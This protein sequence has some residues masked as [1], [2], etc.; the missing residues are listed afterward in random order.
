MNVV[1]FTDT[2]PP[3]INGVS[4]SCYNLTCALKEHGHKVLVITPRNDEGEMEYKDGI[5]YVPGI[6]IKKIYGYRITTVYSSKIINFI[7]EFDP[8]IIH[9]QTDATIGQFAKLAASRLH[10]PIVYTYHT[11]Y[12]DYTYYITHGFLDRLAKKITRTYSNSVAASSTE[13]IT[14]SIKV[15][16]FMRSVGNDIYIN[17]VPTGIDFS[18]FEEKNI[19]EEKIKTFKKEHRIGE[20]TKVFLILGRIAKEKSMDIS[21]DYINKYYEKHPDEDIKLLIVGN[22]PQKEEYE[23][24]VKTLKI[25][26][27]TEFIGAVPANEVPFYYHL[28]DIYTSA[29]VTETQGLTFMEAMAAKT[30]VVARYDDNLSGT[31]IDGKSGFFFQ[32]SES[33]INKIE[34]IFKMSEDEKDKIKKEALEICDMYSIKHFYENIMR[35]YNRAIRKYW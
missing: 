14:P 31:I 21:I 19:D 4:T 30:L 24:L 13:F 20:N 34:T 26:D 1:L 2:Y 5:L 10:V 22:G 6:A 8:D 16:E 3:F 35:T 28:A 32:D 29:S 18:L 27:L 12:E 23:E 7:K 11:S 15:K 9:N 25:K 33:F 17:I